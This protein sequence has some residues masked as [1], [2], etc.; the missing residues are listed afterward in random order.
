MIFDQNVPPYL[1]RTQQ[2]FGS[3]IGGPIDDDSRMNPISP[4]GKSMEVEAADYIAPSPTLRPAQRIQI[5]NQQYWW[6]L[7]NTLHEAFPILTRLFGYFDFNKMIG[8]PYLLKYHP[9]NWSLVTIGDNLT[10]WID[11]EYHAKD[12]E[13]VYQ[14]A[15]MDWAFCNSFITGQMPHLSLENLP[16]P[17]ELD[18][19]LNQILYTQPHLHLFKMPFD[20]FEFRLEFL[21]HP[22]EYWVENDFPQMEL[23]KTYFFALY[24]NSNNDI[25]WKE[26]VE[27]EYYLLSLFQNGTTIDQAC[28]W[29]E[30]QDQV[31][32]ESAMKNL[33]DWFQEW[34]SRGWLTLANP[35][36][37]NFLHLNRT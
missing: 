36:N 25:C 35:C 11:E 28:D 26:I 6:R 34:T 7:L 4:S 10:K 22:P 37:F 19:V 32:F 16:N 13:L 29:L 30:T 1:K 17:E 20:L 24:R 9:S 2:W 33:R 23:D 3:I 27:G 12:K 31:L 14:S 8:I 18:E 21:K 15:R 5:Y